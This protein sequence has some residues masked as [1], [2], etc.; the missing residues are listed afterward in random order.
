M[1]GGASIPQKIAFVGIMRDPLGHWD[2]G[3]RG[4]ALERLRIAIA[5]TRPLTTTMPSGGHKR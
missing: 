4:D 2:A 1:W 5:S 3:A